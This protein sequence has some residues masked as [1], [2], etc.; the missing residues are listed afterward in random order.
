MTMEEK[1]LQEKNKVAKNTAQIILV[2][3]F[4]LVLL[5]FAS[6]MPANFLNIARVI[7]FPVLGISLDI[8]F[9]TNKSSTNFMNIS[10][11]VLSIAYMNI[12]LFTENTYMYAY[13]YLIL[14]YIMVYMDKSFS[15]KWMFGLL[16]MN[17]IIML[18]FMIGVPGTSDIALIQ[19][20]FAT[21]AVI[22]M[23]NI[24]S[25]SSKHEI[26]TMEAISEN[27]SREAEMSTTIV[28]LSK[29]LAGK[30]DIAKETSQTMTENMEQS[31]N[32]VA[33]IAESI[34]VTVDAIE[35][36]TILT[37]E[38]QNNL[39]STEQDTLKM[40][41]AADASSLAVK[42]GR[43]AMELLSKQAELTG[44]LNKKSQETT[45]ELGTRIHDVEEITGEILNISSQ[46]NLLALNASIEAARAGEAGKG[47]AVVADEI[48]QL[49]EQTKNSVNKITDIINRLVENS[50]EASDNMS[51]SIAATEEQNNMVNEAI[52]NIEEIAD[53]N[54][55]LV[56]LMGEISTQIEDILTANTQI[57]ESIS[58]LSAMSQQ[59]SASTETNNNV[60]NASM[61]SVENLNELL[62]EIYKIS[63]A[64]A[65]V[66]KAD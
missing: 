55:I 3:G 60:M 20:V 18:K 54:V 44:E 39:E 37:A 48:R 4:L 6:G 53:K 64:M 42:A 58:N 24:V 32:S 46:T 2:L 22:I 66:T 16:V 29:E 10:S 38:I 13:I 61:V 36:Q 11:I 31:C 49:S 62:N 40:K 65:Q 51:K 17:V 27:A 30:F 19:F 57:S 63:E 59:V 52:Q 21:I 23:Y 7:L 33:E 12:M 45:D 25:L 26:E 43:D 56:D 35:Q 28:S 50:N 15:K 5:G 34:K 1:Q 8:K 14:L 41:E 9:K 47:F